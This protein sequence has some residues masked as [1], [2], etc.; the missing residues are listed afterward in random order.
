MRNILKTTLIAALLTATPAIGAQACFYVAPNGAD[1]APGTRSAP[2]QSLERARDAMRTSDTRCTYL[3]MGE[4]RR[5]QPLLLTQPDNGQVWSA[6]PSDP[7]LQAHLNGQGTLTDIILIQGGSHIT[8]DGLKMSDVLY[9]GVGIHGG[10]AHIRDFVMGTDVPPAMDNI[11]RNTEVYNISAPRGFDSSFW[12]TGG[13]AAVGNVKSTIIENNY[14]HDIASMGLRIVNSGAKDHDISGARI[15]NNI[16]KRAVRTISDAGSIYVQDIY[17][18]GTDIEIKGNFV[19]DFQGPSNGQGR[20]IYLDM[21]TS[22][23]TIED[24]V[25][26]AGPHAA[27]GTSAIITSGGN[28]ILIKNNIIDLGSTGRVFPFSYIRPVHF[29]TDMKNVSFKSN[30]ILAEFSGK[31]S[32]HFVGT[33]GFA[34]PCGGAISTPATITFNMYHNSAGGEERTDGNCSGDQNPIHANPRVIGANYQIA[35]GSPALA[36]PLDFKTLP[37]LWGPRPKG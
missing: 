20:G 1:G 29:S 34:Y 36:A 11:V 4:Y 19:E 31:Q 28:N 5:T 18:R 26:V 9:R 27:E 33:R 24:N 30:I 17:G 6:D 12:N 3:R 22:N 13:V 25:I 37:R 16:V 15:T 8:I 35:P 32:T 2:F 10:Q 7:P 21:A 23:T 14:F